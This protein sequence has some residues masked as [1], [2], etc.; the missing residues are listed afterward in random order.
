LISGCPSEPA[1]HAELAQSFERVLSGRGLSLGAPKVCELARALAD[2]ALEEQAL[3]RAATLVQTQIAAVLGRA[4]PVRAL[5][6]ADM[7]AQRHFY[8]TS[9]PFPY[10]AEDL[11]RELE[12]ELHIEP[13]TILLCDAREA[14]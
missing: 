8:E 3:T 7:A 9:E 2:Y 12:I 5:S 11:E 6:A 14:R 1:L 10:L 13:N 4:A